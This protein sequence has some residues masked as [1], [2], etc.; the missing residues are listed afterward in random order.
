MKH[1]FPVFLLKVICR[2]VSFNA[3]FGSMTRVIRDEMFDHLVRKND[4][5][6]FP[7]SE[8]RRK[9]ILPV[10]SLDNDG[11]A[12]IYHVCDNEN[13][14]VPVVVIHD[15]HDRLFIVA[16][17]LVRQKYIHNKRCRVISPEAFA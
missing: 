9:N 16:D 17:P 11:S 10:N 15:F 8:Y 2:E 7:A 5:N 1:A 4:T 12:C 6:S 14:D 13:S 3:V